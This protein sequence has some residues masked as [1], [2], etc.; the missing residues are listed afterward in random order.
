MLSTDHTPEP[1]NTTPM[2][3]NS[4][5]ATNI[6]PNTVFTVAPAS[7]RRTPASPLCSFLGAW[8]VPPGVV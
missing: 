6:Q 8:A 2:V 4:P 7:A 3:A 1:S 5:K